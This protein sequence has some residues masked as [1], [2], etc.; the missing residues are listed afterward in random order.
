MAEK[1]RVDRIFS[2]I[3]NNPVLAVIIALGIIVIALSSFTNAAK[4]LLGLFS[5]QSTKTPATARVFVTG[6]W[7]TPALS[8][9]YNK[10]QEFIFT[11][12]LDS[13]GTT[14]IGTLTLTPIGDNRSYKRGIR[15]G[16][17]EGNTISFYTQETGWLGKESV[18]YK[19]L[20][21]GTVSKDKIEFIQTSERP[22]D[23]IPQKFIAKRVN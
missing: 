16:K 21:N 18:S 8:N 20:F 5:N 17:I 10:K 1:T 9:Q 14:L 13:K 7:K 2:K 11:F 3:K 19:D 12:E 23:F 6:T 22:W 4:N 15:G